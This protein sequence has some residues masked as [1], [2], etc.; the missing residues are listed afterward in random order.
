MIAVN[1]ITY[2]VEDENADSGQHI[3]ENFRQYREIYNSIFLKTIFNFFEQFFKEFL[4]I[5]F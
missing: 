5:F 3:K 2:K 1:T 4:K